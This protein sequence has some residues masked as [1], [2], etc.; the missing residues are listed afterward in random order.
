MDFLLLSSDVI[1]QPALSQ[2]RIVPRLAPLL[3]RLPG[4]QTA[5]G[6]QD[7]FRISSVRPMPLPPEVAKGTT[8]LPEK[9]QEARNVSMMRGA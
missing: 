8:R 3:S 4:S 7:F 1:L 6:E 5:F 2:L 9:S